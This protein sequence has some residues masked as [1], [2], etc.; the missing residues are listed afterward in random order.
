MLYNRRATIEPMEFGLYTLHS[1]SIVQLLCN[2]IAERWQL[3]HNGH[4]HGRP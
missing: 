4:W 3:Y 2:V 1:H